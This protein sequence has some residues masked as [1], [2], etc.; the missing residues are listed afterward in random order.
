MLQVEQLG[1]AKLNGGL[2]RVFH[3][4]S[5]PSILPIAGSLIIY[6]D[7]LDEAGDMLVQVGGLF[8]GLVCVCLR[9]CVGI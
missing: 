6:D 2:P 7:V 3:D 9:Q 4:D 5:L 1:L 8:L